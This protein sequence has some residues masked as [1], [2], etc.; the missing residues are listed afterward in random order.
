VDNVELRGGKEEQC[1]AKLLGKLAR[2]IQRNTA[3]VCVTQ[4]VV[5]VVGQQL[6]DETQV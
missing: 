6:K 1:C 5:E 4:Q 3:E 2:Q